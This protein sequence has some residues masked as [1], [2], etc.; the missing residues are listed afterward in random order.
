MSWFKAEFA[1]S[2]IISGLLSVVIVSVIC[3]LAIVQVPV[4]D[5]LVAACSSVIAFFFGA[6][7]G[8]RTGYTEAMHDIDRDQNGGKRGNI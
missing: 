1:K 3:Y 5:V 6:R 7:Q 2:T 8:A 4:P